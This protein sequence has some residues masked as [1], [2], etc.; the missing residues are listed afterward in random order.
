MSSHIGKN[1]L[2]FPPPR[3]ITV[4]MR[5]LIWKQK[6]CG[7]YVLDFDKTNFELCGAATWNVDY[8]GGQVIIL[9]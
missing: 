1:F 2:N 5:F 7:R 8:A 3:P 9:F 6:H 4:K